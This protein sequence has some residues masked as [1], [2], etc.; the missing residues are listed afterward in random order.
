V[1]E[2]K[3][4]LFSSGGLSGGFT[5]RLIQRLEAHV[6]TR[7]RDET[8]AALPLV[9]GDHEIVSQL[10]QGA[11]RRRAEIRM[12]RLVDLELLQRVTER[13]IDEQSL[14]I[15][16]PELPVLRE[17][18]CQNI[19][20]AE[21]DLRRLLVVLNMTNTPAR[22]HNFE[23]GANVV[24]ENLV[25]NLLADSVEMLNHRI[26][27]RGEAVDLV[28]MKSAHDLGESEG[29]DEGASLSLPP[30]DLP[31]KCNDLSSDREYRSPTA[32]DVSWR[33]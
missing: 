24:A 1:C 11:T 25:A 26:M 22:I 10:I 31:A 8:L 4:P 21:L 3:Q 19:E 27:L 23:E 14:V 33:L 29:A 18:A 30:R 2:A 28:H 12:R 13:N 32:F 5:L 6:A 7:T 17:E 20:K 15:A 16:A 9:N